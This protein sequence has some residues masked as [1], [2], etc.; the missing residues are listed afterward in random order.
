M[1]QRKRNVDNVSLQ[2]I[3]LYGRQSIRHVHIFKQ[4]LSHS[5]TSLSPKQRPAK[6]WELK[7]PNG[8]VLAQK[9]TKLPNEV[10][11]RYNDLVTG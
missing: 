5:L 7:L 6:L 3:E 8:P 9:T 2:L 10:Q 1:G 11:R 4:S